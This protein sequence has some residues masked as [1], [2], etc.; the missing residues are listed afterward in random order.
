MDIGRTIKQKVRD[1]VE[2][3]FNKDIKDTVSKTMRPTT[4]YKV[5]ETTRNSV[6]DSTLSVYGDR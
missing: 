3:Y 4:L 5:I 2:N 6:W 1:S